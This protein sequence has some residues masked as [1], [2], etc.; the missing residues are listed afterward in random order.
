MTNLCKEKFESFKKEKNISTTKHLIEVIKN[1]RID[2][3]IDIVM[4][5]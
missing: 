3:L 5:G 4:E 2:D 1:M